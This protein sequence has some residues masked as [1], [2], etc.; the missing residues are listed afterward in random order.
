MRLHPGLHYGHR[1][2][3][4]VNKKNAW[5]GFII[6][7]MSIKHIKNGSLFIKSIVSSV[8]SKSIL[9]LLR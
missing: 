6:I 7:V 3:S 8:Y 4:N 5:N 2:I 1:I 9:S